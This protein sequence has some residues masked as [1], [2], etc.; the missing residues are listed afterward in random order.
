[1]FLNFFIKKIP[2]NNTKVFKK[3]RFTNKIMGLFDEMLK[4]NETL[5]KNPIALD[6]DFIPKIVPFREGEQKRIATAILPLLHGRNGKNL[7]ITGLPGIG[8]T[9]AAKKV[10]EELEEETDE[11]IPI[12][13]NCWNK[14]TTYKILTSIAEQINYPFTQNKK[15]EELFKI[16]KER[17]NQNAAVFVFDEIDKA[18][19]LDFLYLL[20][21]EIYKSTIILITNYKEWII[22]LEDRIKSRLTLEHLEF[23]PYSLE[24]TKKIILER[25]KIAFYE[26]VIGEEEINLIAQ[27]TYKAKDIRRGLYLLKEAG[28]NAE[29]KGRK[30]II[31]ED[32]KKAEEKILDFKI[33]KTEELTEEEKKILEIIK[34]NDAKKIGQLYEEYIKTL[35]EEK[36]EKISYKT[37]QRKIK[38][39]EQG[40]YIT[41]KTL[42]GGKEGRTSI[43]FYN[44][45]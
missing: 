36:K 7:F 24:E 44:S 38:K 18:E 2:Y 35:E 31:L 25:T 6:Y 45:I 43:I 19:E 33:K 21:E 28:N 22:K 37:F 4:S 14:N 10:L 29:E 39:L 11:I 13:I 20:V 34:K 41:V 1:M 5:F 42:T 40:K 17:I 15:T 3:H 26:N 8:K 30:K 16:I 27:K 32:I 23:K 9:L 12:Y